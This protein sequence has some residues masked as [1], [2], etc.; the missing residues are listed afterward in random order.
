MEANKLDI[1]GN[2]AGAKT[3][4]EEA[5]GYLNRAA[6]YFEKALARQP[7][8]LTL[9]RKLKEIYLRLLQNDKADA[10]D[11]KINQR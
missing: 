9:M 6:S 2:K 8:D 5:D 11:K 7:D 10:I 3:L 1:D 4:K